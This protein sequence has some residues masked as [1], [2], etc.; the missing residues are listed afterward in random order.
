MRNVRHSGETGDLVDES[1][2]LGPGRQNQ[3]TAMK[4]TE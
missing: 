4:L 2:G 1:V 3:W